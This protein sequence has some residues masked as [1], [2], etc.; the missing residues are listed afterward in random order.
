MRIRIHRN[1]VLVAL[2]FGVI[3]LLASVTFAAFLTGSFEILALVP[4]SLLLWIVIFVWAAAR[5]ARRGKG[6][7]KE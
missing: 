3:A 1:A 2:V 5:L 7:E 6:E 4:L